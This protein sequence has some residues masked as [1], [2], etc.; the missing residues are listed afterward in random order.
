MSL[1]LSLQSVFADFRLSAQLSLL[2]VLTIVQITPY[3]CLLFLFM[4][5]L[6]NKS[7]LLHVPIG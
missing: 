1:A 7:L 5:A 4:L 2:F 3:M 6:L